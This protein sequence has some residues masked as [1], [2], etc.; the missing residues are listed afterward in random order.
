MGY[1][2][3][4]RDRVLTTPTFE[5]MP[6]TLI[7]PIPKPRRERIIVQRDKLGRIVHSK[8]PAQQVYNPTGAGAGAA[9]A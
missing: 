5:L 8:P 3:K 6:F 9:G 2:P 7:A 4:N 1:E